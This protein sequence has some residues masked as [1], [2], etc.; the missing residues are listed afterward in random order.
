MTD[1]GFSVTDIMS[2]AQPIVTLI[3]PILA[4]V[5]AIPLAFT[6]ARKTKNLF[7]GR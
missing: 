2:S 5:V 6:I 7:S 1:L 3:G 4:F